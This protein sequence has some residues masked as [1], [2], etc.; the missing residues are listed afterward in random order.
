MIN[1]NQISGVDD[2]NAISNH[3]FQAIDDSNCSIKSSDTKLTTSW[4]QHEVAACN[5]LLSPSNSKQEEFHQGEMQLQYNLG[6][7]ES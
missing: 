7:L 3:Q 1:L 2:N 5:S 6:S 4:T